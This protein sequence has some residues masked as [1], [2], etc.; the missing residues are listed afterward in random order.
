MT[1]DISI[2]VIGLCLFALL[3]ILVPDDFAMP[4]DE[5]GNL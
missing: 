5:E 1:H 3:A 4:V 2:V